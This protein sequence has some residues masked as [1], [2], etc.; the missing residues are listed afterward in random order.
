MNADGPP[1]AAPPTAPL[2]EVRD[3]VVTYPSRGPA[4]A[5]TRA[6]DGIS[7]TVPRGGSLGLVGESGS[8]KS[9][10]GRAV[11]RLVRAQSGAVLFDGVDLLAL[12]GETLRRVRRRMQ[13]VFQDPGGSLNPRM[14][15]GA[16]VAEPLIIHGLA[17]DAAAARRA[18][19][20]LLAR[21]GLGPDA[22]DRFPHQFSGGQR[23][24]IAIAR[25]IAARP[26][27]IVCDE[28]TSA[29]DVSVQAQIINLLMDLQSK[30]GLSYLFISHDIGLVQHVCSHL[31]VMKSGRIVEA[32]PAG[33]I[34]VRPSHP[35]T[36]ALLA[37]VPVAPT[38][39]EPALAT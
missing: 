12:R 7:F 32:G 18:A 3:L 11:L 1:S 20:D 39:A 23:Q 28:P 34:L 9:T 17:S 10:V 24:R 37:A 22:C 8:G 27:F 36:R 38:P 33:E 4:R 2:L 19:V 30:F 31:A 35:Y 25:A 15:A 14:R 5:A 13:I 6:V 26:E 29:L 21:C 16:I